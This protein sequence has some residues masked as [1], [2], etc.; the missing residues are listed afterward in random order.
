MR[1]LRHHNRMIKPPSSTHPLE[2][3]FARILVKAATFT[4]VQRLLTLI[5]KNAM[6]TREFEIGPSIKESFC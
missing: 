3:A 6:Q 1:D 4:N 5:E 2:T